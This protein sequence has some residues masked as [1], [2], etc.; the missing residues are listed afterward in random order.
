MGIALS[1]MIA[2]AAS[3]D[4]GSSRGWTHRAEAE[5]VPARDGEWVRICVRP[6]PVPPSTQRTGPPVGQPL[7][8]LESIRVRRAAWPRAVAEL[9]EPLDPYRL[10]RALLLQML[11][12][13]EERTIEAQVGLAFLARSV[14]RQELAL[15]LR[16]AIA[17][18][19]AFLTDQIRSARIAGGLSSN[20][21]PEKAAVTLLALT[22]GLAAYTLAGRLSPEDAVQILDAQ[23]RDLLDA[24]P[25]KIVSALGAARMHLT[26]SRSGGRRCS[27]RKCD[28]GHSATSP[29]Q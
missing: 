19:G 15:R 9:A 7:S 26:C 13:D 18:L 8:P 1:D 12:L 20:L 10:V 3:N 6:S 2:I 21:P 27:E 5:D 14:V 24:A 23:L 28:A 22:D 4:A 17:Q 11:P 29:L 25:G 16:E